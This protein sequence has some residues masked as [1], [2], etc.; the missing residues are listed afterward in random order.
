[1]PD[2]FTERPAFCYVKFCPVLLAY[3]GA[4]PHH[5]HF[6]CSLTLHRNGGKPWLKLIYGS[7]ILIFIPQIL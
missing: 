5:F 2:T 3:T 4:A 6:G 7:I 1:M